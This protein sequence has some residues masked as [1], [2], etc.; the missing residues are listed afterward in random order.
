MIQQQNTQR[1]QQDTP[2]LYDGIDESKD[3]IKNKHYV[4]TCG[5]FT[6]SVTPVASPRKSPG[7]F[8]P[9]F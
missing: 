8:L 9:S 3:D 7:S 5:S 2:N 4:G 6:L 1:G